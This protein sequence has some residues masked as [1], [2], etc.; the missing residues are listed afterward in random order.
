MG[1][2]SGS[3]PQTAFWEITPVGR[4]A[5]AIGQQEDRA[6]SQDVEGSSLGQTQGAG[7]RRDTVADAE[8]GISSSRP[9]SVGPATVRAHVPHVAPERSGGGSFYQHRR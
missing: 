6:V 7:R 1:R 3:W 9:G 4:E 5:H 2:A 8:F